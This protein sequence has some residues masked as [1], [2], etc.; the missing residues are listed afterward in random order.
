[1]PPFYGI[2]QLSWEISK[3]RIKTYNKETVVTQNGE[4]GIVICPFAQTKA[5][6]GYN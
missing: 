6:E 2:S 1:M 4:N 5:L 3:C